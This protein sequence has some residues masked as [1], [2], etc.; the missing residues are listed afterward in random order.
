M[1]AGTGPTAAAPD[2]A[3]GAPRPK[4][5]KRSTKDDTERKKGPLAKAVAAAPPAGV[6]TAGIP[7]LALDAYR[8]AAEE[9]AVRTPGCHLPWTLLAAIGHTESNHARGGAL[10][11]EGFT[12]S[13]I[14]GPV[15]N[16]GPFAA[17]RDSDGGEL[18]GDT[19]WDRAV[20]PM[21][22]IPSTWKRWGTTTRPTL[23]ADPNNIFDAS[24][25]AAA[26][27]CAGNRDLDDPVQRR[28][29][30]LSYN[31][32]QDYLRDVLAWNS[33]Y[34]SGQSTMTVATA[35]AGAGAGGG[36]AADAVHRSG[37]PV[38]PMPNGTVVSAVLP[39]STPGG[40]H[41]PRPAG[42]A[43]S[44]PARAASPT[45]PQQLPPPKDTVTTPAPAPSAPHPA[46]TPQP[47]ETPAPRP[48]GVRPALPQPRPDVPTATPSRRATPVSLTRGVTTQL[49]GLLRQVGGILG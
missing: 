13:P 46:A 7:A 9:Q 14:L 37:E 8:R 44:T 4:P 47:D 11:D 34:A 42:S 29:A 24:T 6:T 35:G 5:E 21:Q 39:R 28:R 36:G 41:L 20:G 22:F 26:Y 31:P 25:T 1:Y 27:L 49:T 38:R 18:D 17:L 30:V 16:G 32:S 12:T 48:G 40:R 3:P 33:A 2:A 45:V 23:V 15:L 19:I 10:T 43:R